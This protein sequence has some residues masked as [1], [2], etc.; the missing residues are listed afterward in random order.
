MV[1][2]LKFT[3]HLSFTYFWPQNWL[4]AVNIH[5]MLPYTDYCWLLSS[6]LLLKITGLIHYSMLLH[7]WLLLITAGPTFSS[8]EGLMQIKLEPR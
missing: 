7:V 2:V 3:Q 6:C 1:T 8:S 4:V 5:F